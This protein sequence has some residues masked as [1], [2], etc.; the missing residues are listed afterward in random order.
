MDSPIKGII[1]ASRAMARE[2]RVEAKANTQMNLMV[3]ALGL[4]IG[5]MIRGMD[6]MS[7]SQS[8]YYCFRFS[9]SVG[10]TCVVHCLG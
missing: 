8:P 9:M 2:I 7:Q 10:V 6:R 3:K 1:R 4:M 5:F